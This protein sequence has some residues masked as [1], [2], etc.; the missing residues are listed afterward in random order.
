MDTTGSRYF[1]VSYLMAQPIRDLIPL[2]RPRSRKAL[3][4]ELYTAD[5]LRPLIKEF[6]HLKGGILES[7]MGM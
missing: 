2:L 4:D 7:D 5:Q 1:L 6:P 3:L